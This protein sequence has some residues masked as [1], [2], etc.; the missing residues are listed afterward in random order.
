[1]FRA[2]LRE[3]LQEVIHLLD[4]LRGLDPV[5]AQHHIRVALPHQKFAQVLV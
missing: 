1:M 3:G 2:E 5:L 4:L